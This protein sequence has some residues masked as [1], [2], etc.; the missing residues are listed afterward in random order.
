MEWLS[1]LVKRGFHFQPVRDGQGEITLLV[2][3]FGWHGFYDRIHIWAED[4]AV[5]ARERNDHRPYIGNVVW[6]YDGATADVAQALLGLPKPG[7]PGAPTIARYSPNT[8][9]LPLTSQRH[10]RPPGRSAL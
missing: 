5:A 7:E 1:E 8:L 9:W 6:S 3:S 2:G 4:E 10:R